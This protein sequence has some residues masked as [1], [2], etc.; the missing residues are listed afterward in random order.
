MVTYSTMGMTRLEKRLAL[1]FLADLQITGQAHV[2][3]G[4]WTIDYV[5]S[6]HLATLKNVL[7]CSD[8]SSAVTARTLSFC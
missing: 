1:I 7:E 4:V 2:A 8:S 5:P 6:N 3:F